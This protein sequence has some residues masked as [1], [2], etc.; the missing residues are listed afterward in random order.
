MLAR[1]FVGFAL[2]ILV[3]TSG[4]A[5]KEQGPAP[6]GAVQLVRGSQNHLLVPASVNGHPASFLLDTAERLTFLQ[7]DRVTPFGVRNLG[8]QTHVGALWFSLGEI[9]RLGLGSISFS[10]VE[11][12]L[13]DSQFR[14]PVPGRGGK[15]ADGIIGLDLLR[16]HRAVIN[17]RTQQL[18]LQTD[19]ASNLNLAPTTSGLGFTRI[20][21]SEDPSGALTVPCSIGDKNGRLA[22]DTGAFVTIFN[23]ASIRE[24]NLK[25]DASKLTARTAAGRVRPLALGQIND[26][27]IGG[28]P[29][30]PQKFAVMDLFAAKKPARV[31][32]GI[33]RLEYYDMRTPRSKQDI[34]GLLGSELLYQRSAIIDLN[35]MSLFL[36]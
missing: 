36:K 12:A 5:T 31:F 7:A 16:R 24:L 17:C 34:F 2:L 35:S 26:L 28:V 18:F 11:V 6:N 25:E 23:Q 30:A 20:P 1:G 15:A 4:A 29:I 9:D 8:R 22:L 14:G 21:I 10:P 33:N 19:N 13:Y 3:G 32:T 27:K